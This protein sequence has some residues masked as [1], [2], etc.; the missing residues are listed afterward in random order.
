MLFQS[1]RF[2]RP[3]IFEDVFRSYSWPEERTLC[4]ALT[5]LKSVARKFENC[6]VLR[7]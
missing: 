6:Q 1:Y 2:N 3:S 7:K 5:I 4:V